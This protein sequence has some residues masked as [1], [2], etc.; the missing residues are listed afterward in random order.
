MVRKLCTAGLPIELMPDD[1]LASRWDGHWKGERI[2]VTGGGLAYPWEA[3]AEFRRWL[4]EYRSKRLP[5]WL[6]EQ[7]YAGAATDADAAS[8][9]AVL[10]VKIG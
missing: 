6:D 4:H 2:D 9:L 8:A 7:A 10:G 5:V 3:L 1:D